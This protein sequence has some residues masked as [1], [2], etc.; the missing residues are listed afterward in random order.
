M[1]STQDIINRLKK[2]AQVVKNEEDTK[3]SKSS[4]K[5]LPK[6]KDGLTIYPSF[7]K[8]NL[9]K[10][11]LKGIYSIGYEKPSLVQS[12]AIVPII[13]GKDIIIQQQSGTGKTATF[14]IAMLQVLYGLSTANIKKKTDGLQALVISPTRELAI[15]ING[16]IEN[17]G[18]Y[19]KVDSFC[20]TGLANNTGNDKVNNDK[21]IK[22][23]LKKLGNADIVS[24]TPGKIVDCL[25]RNQI[26]LDNLKMIILD[27]ADELLDEHLGF[28]K[29]IYEIFSKINLKTQ[30]VIL[31]AT[32]SS[33]IL[34]VS[35]KIMNWDN[36][37]KILT[38]KKEISLDVIKQYKVEL[39]ENWKFNTLLDILNTVSY[40]QAV[41]FV[42]NV[43]KCDSLSKFLNKQKFSIVSIHSKLSQ[44]ERLEQM[45]KF[46]NG[47][48]KILV[49]TDIWARG[50][51]VQQINLVINYDLPTIIENYIHRIGRSGRF[52][53]LGKA[54]NFVTDE[55][56]KQLSKIEKYYKIEIPDMPNDI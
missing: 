19:L 52:G 18:T 27:E 12:K 23:D 2:R 10:E 29:Q 39:K 47:T 4:I 15:Q 5:E 7:N 50:I 37:I 34:E 30:V 8:M 31:S 22:L 32:M 49:T 25:K 46:R 36:H 38:K 21:K 40:Q 9:N 44:L 3:Q 14:T 33:N 16:V 48:Y 1:S 28:K 13:S 43:K 6:S 45:N 41:I 54:I 11:L 55:D 35:K 51:D 20:L 26:S 56:E 53:R 42:N 24:G 17:L